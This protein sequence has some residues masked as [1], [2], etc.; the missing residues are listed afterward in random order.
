MNADFSSIFINHFIIFI[1]GLDKPSRSK[2]LEHVLSIRIFVHIEQDLLKFLLKC[3]IKFFSNHKATFRLL[4]EPFKNYQVIL[5]AAVRGFNFLEN[6]VLCN[7]DIR[8]SI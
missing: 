1:S 3:N 4:R 5:Y 6:S 7:T 8:L 2:L